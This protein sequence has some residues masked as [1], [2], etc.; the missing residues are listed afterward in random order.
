[1][2]G[3]VFYK[4]LHAK[5]NI[6][7]ACSM[8]CSHTQSCLSLSPSAVA[9]AGA[10]CTASALPTSALQRM[11]GP[12]H[13]RCRH[14][15]DPCRIYACM[16]IMLS[17]GSDHQQACSTEAGYLWGSKLF[18]QWQH[19]T[20]GRQPNPTSHLP[21]PLQQL[22]PLGPGGGRAGSTFQRHCFFLAY[23]STAPATPL[24]QGYGLG[25]HQRL[26]REHHGSR[27][28]CACCALFKSGI[29]YEAAADPW[30][31]PDSLDQ[32]LGGCFEEMC[33]PS[34][35]GRAVR[36]YVDGI[37]CSCAMHLR[38]WQWCTLFSTA[39]NSSSLPL[40]PCLCLLALPS[41][42]CCVPYAYTTPCMGVRAVA[43]SMR[44]HISSAP[45]W[46]SAKHHGPSGG[47][48]R[49]CHG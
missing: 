37:A 29:C 23:S 17:L 3:N 45:A 1:M 16:A 48:N 8:V 43:R 30:V 49:L 11:A 14:V 28:G 5:S 33:L 21:S 34:V 7:S 18:W 19:P 13:A 41:P 9:Y 40:W 6:P 4:R 26:E 27:Y 31:I 46:P 12:A 15:E 35:Y 25:E 47:S 24:A 22:P 42:Y 2:V 32:W 44:A 10:R 39:H 36:L 38:A 20:A